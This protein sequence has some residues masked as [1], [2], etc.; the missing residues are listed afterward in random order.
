MFRWRTVL[1]GLSESHPGKE[2]PQLYILYSSVLYLNLFIFSTLIHWQVNIFFFKVTLWCLR[3]I[4]QFH[5]ALQ[6]NYFTLR[7]VCESHLHRWEASFI[8]SC[9]PPLRG[10]PPRISLSCFNYVFIGNFQIVFRAI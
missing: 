1:H 6:Y 2:M 3:A 8:G 10:S 4:F 9:P 5:N 7:V